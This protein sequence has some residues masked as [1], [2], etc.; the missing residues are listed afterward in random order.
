MNRTTATCIA[1]MRSK[2]ATGIKTR[3]QRRKKPREAKPFTRFTR[4]FLAFGFGILAK[5]LRW[6]PSATRCHVALLRIANLE[7]REAKP[8]C[9]DSSCASAANPSSSS[10]LPLVHDFSSRNSLSRRLATA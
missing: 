4:R 2:T 10:G 1:G 5:R 9:A 6:R 3:F 7:P 8:F